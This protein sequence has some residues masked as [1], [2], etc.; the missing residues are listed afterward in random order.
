LVNETITIKNFKRRN[1]MKIKQTLITLSLIMMISILLLSLTWSQAFGRDKPYKIDLYTYQV[2]TSTFAI[3]TAISTLLAEKGS[4]LKAAVMESPSPWVSNRLLIEDPSMRKK[5]IAYILPEHVWVGM[6]P[7]DKYDPPYEGLRDIAAF[8]S[9]FN[10]WVTN[11]PK[12]KTAKDLAGKKVAIRSGQPG[13]PHYEM[14]TLIASGAKGAKGVEF[15]FTGGMRAL[16]DG[17]VDAAYI[18]GFVS[19]PK[20]LRFIPPPVYTELLS[21][22]KNLNYISYKP[23][24]VNA[25]QK[26]YGLSPNEIVVPPGGYQKT[27]TVPWRVSSNTLGWGCDKSMPEDVVY[28]FV[29]AMGDNAHRIVE[30]HRSGKAISIEFMPRFGR[31]TLMHPGALRY[32]QE[33]GVDNLIGRAWV[34]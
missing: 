9:I 12:I 15:S 30:F 18:A 34:E 13:V 31:K 32:Y 14:E 26:K 20:N 6:P 1:Q 5:V 16:I 7:F 4:W 11:N 3:G 27:Q 33:K 2:G 28:E 23:G 24:T 8:G 17:L 29:K 25:V 22:A 21:T 19:D 10:G